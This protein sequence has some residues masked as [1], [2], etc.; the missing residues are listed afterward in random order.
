M[1]VVVTKPKSDLNNSSKKLAKMNSN[2]AI[3]LTLYQKNKKDMKWKKT[4]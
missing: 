1:Q 3:V 4:E 2:T